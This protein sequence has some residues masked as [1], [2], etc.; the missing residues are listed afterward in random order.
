MQAENVWSSLEVAKLLVSLLT[1]VLVVIIGYWLNRRLN[2]IDQENQRRSQLREE[3]QQRLRDEIERRH[4]PHIEFTINC[5]LFGPV[6]GWYIAE[7]V[8]TA[9]NVSLVRH[10]FPEIILRVRGIKQ[11]ETPELWDGHGD[12][13]EFRHKLFEANVVLEKWNYIFVEPGVAQ[14][15][16]YVT[17][18]E[19]AY[20]YILARAEF[21]YDQFTPHSIE[22]MFEVTAAILPVQKFTNRDP[23]PITSIGKIVAS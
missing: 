20:R 7:F 18:I 23:E 2:E 5:N 1:P 17:R 15:I 21:H 8:I 12:R 19:E 3:E 10:Q 14:Q 13:L 16:T 4:D 9:K 6:A 11:D 22:R